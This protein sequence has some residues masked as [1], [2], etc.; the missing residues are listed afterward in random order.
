MK[1]KCVENRNGSEWYLTVGKVYDAGEVKNSSYPRAI[2]CI[3]DDTGDM[4][5]IYLKDSGHG[6]FEVVEE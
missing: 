5:N 2:V 6:K 1:I 3:T 4:V